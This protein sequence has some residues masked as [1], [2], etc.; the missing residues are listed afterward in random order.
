[1]LNLFQYLMQETLLERLSMNNT[2][3]I[4]CR[5]AGYPSVDVLRTHL[6]NKGQTCLAKSGHN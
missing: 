6:P 1:M 2:K 5:E 4:V 3:K